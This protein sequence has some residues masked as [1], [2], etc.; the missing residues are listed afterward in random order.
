MTGG[1][2]LVD[3]ARWCAVGNGRHHVA[4]QRQ[5]A[6]QRIAEVGVVVGQQDLGTSRDHGP[7]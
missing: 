5:Q 4:I 2:S 1:L 3:R 7:L 6:F